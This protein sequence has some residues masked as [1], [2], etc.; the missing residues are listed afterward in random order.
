MLNVS[1]IRH[2]AHMIVEFLPIGMSI[3]LATEM[4]TC[5]IAKHK[6]TKQIVIICQCL[7]HFQAEIFACH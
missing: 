1:T 2:T 3:H 4:K 5:F 6:T 7:L